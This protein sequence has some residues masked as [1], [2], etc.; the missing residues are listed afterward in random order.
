MVLSHLF[1]HVVLGSKSLRL[2]S[3]GLTFNSNNED[4]TRIEI[5]N[6]NFEIPARVTYSNPQDKFG[7]KEKARGSNQSNSSIR[8]RII[9][10]PHFSVYLYWIKQFYHR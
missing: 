7:W 9:R 4:L 8:K 5:T 1:I 6:D 10:A 3:Q 2:L